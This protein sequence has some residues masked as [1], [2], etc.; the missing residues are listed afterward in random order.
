MKQKELEVDSLQE[1]INFYNI[2]KK[3]LRKELKDTVRLYSKK[4][5]DLQN[6][7]LSEVTAIESEL[8]SLRQAV[9]DMES[10]LVSISATS[11]QQASNAAYSNQGTVLS[12]DLRAG[13]RNAWHTF[14]LS[15]KYVISS[16]FDVIARLVDI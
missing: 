7:R 14:A 1:K 11:S 9:A 16:V 13:L 15:D 12:T 10:R 6:Q 2:E 8:K 4:Y 5:E 3:H